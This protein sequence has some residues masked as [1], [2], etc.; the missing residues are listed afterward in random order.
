MLKPP[1]TPENRL[2]AALQRMIAARDRET[3]TFRPLVL[4]AW[5]DLQG[6]FRSAQHDLAESM[7][8]ADLA[9]AAMSDFASMPASDVAALCTP[10]AGWASAQ[11]SESVKR[12]KVAVLAR[13][14]GI[15]AYQAERTARGRRVAALNEQTARDRE[16]AAPAQ[17]LARLRS[18]GV[19]LTVDRDKITVP[20]GCQLGPQDLSAVIHHKAALLELLTQEAA[21]SR[22][23]VI[24]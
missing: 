6:W 12:A 14:A 11:M 20:A 10:E 2:R 15:V 18:A 5:R 22:P 4:D 16:S 7:R 21:A 17:L 13:H 1:D 19:K 9:L 3:I 8:I 24:A 23:L